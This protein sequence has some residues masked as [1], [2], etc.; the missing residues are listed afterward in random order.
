MRS[1]SYQ[2]PC[3]HQSDSSPTPGAASHSQELMRG[4]VH[5]WTGFGQSLYR[6]D[7]VRGHW[8]CT[9][10]GGLQDE[11]GALAPWPPFLPPTSCLRSTT[12]DTRWVPRRWTWRP[13]ESFAREGKPRGKQWAIFLLYV[14]LFWPFHSLPVHICW[15]LLLPDISHGNSCS[16]QISQGWFG[17][18]GIEQ[19]SPRAITLHDFFMAVS[20]SGETRLF[21]YQAFFLCVLIIAIAISTYSISDRYAITLIYTST[22]LLTQRRKWESNGHI[23]EPPTVQ[24]A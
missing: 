9:L 10:P 18:R 21:S 15:V 12:S 8:H 22:P 2:Q 1:L 3:Q 19:V 7:L 20:L 24:V 4:S 23:S 5:M 11:I 6:G 16:F 13:W 14:H 17:A